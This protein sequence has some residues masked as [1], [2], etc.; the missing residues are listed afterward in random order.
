[1]YSD[2]ENPENTG[3][4]TNTPP[5]LTGAVGSTITFNLLKGVAPVIVIVTVGNRTGDSPITSSMHYLL[6]KGR[7]S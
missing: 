3:S 2:N 6:N 1:M 5:Q 4:I 7:E